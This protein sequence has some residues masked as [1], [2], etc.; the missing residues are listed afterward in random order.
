MIVGIITR[1][2][3]DLQ[4]QL[5]PKQGGPQALGFNLHWECLSK[6]QTRVENNS[7]TTEEGRERAIKTH[8][9]WIKCVPHEAN[10]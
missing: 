5:K 4:P 9:E 7:I 2:R 3:D 8:A 6:F 1:E 10:S